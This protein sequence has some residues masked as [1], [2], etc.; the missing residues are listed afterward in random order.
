ML[1]PMLRTIGFIDSILIEAGPQ[2]QRDMLRVAPPLILAAKIANIFQFLPESQR[3]TVAVTTI[4][5]VMAAIA[6]GGISALV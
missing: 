1:K 3:G 4:A 6:A 5:V 2:A